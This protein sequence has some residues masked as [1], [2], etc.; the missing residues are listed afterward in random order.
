M[1]QYFND[2]NSIRNRKSLRPLFSNIDVQIERQGIGGVASMSV[3]G[4]ECQLGNWKRRLLHAAE[5]DPSTTRP[6]WSQRSRTGHRTG[7]TVPFPEIEVMTHIL[8]Y[9]TELL[10]LFTYVGALKLS[11]NCMPSKAFYCDCHRITP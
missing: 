5:R 3:F 11:V 9:D 7:T 1:P 6:R 10:Q 8:S 4:T 2:N